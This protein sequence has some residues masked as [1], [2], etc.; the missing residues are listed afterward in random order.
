LKYPVYE[1][2]L[3]FQGEGVHMGR[4]AY[5]LRLYGCDQKCTFCDSAGTWHPDFKPTNVP[6]VP[7][8]QVVDTV[9]A[10][11]RSASPEVF[12]VI[13]GGEPT[14][15]NLEPLVTELK[16][17]GLPCHI[18]TAG[19]HDPPENA[20]WITLSPKLFGKPPTTKAWCYANEIKLICESP[21]QML[22]DADKI[23]QAPFRHGTPIW[24]HPEW[25]RRGDQLLLDSITNLVKADSRFRAGYQL[26]KLFAADR[27][28]PNSLP[29]V[30]L[31]G[32]STR[33]KD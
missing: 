12:V 16:M 25:S 26:H 8:Q 4:A 13:T 30:P 10:A 27:Q 15:Y 2:F 18:E 23:L 6:L 7:L 20:A 9:F 19:H 11:T 17:E 5:F 29:D 22:R 14:L 32:I 3:S 31:G 33:A 28:D 21:A 1:Q 24:L